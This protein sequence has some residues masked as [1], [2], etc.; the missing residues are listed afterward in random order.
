MARFQL[1]SYVLTYSNCLWT[2]ISLHHIQVPACFKYPLTLVDGG[3]T[4]WTE[5]SQCSVDGKVQR[6]RSCNNPSPLLGA[7]CQGENQQ[8]NNCGKFCKHP[9]LTFTQPQVNLN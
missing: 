5:W 6:K 7:P 2:L 1:I 4:T 3:W 9:N 8:E